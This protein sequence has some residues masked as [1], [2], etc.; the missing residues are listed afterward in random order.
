MTIIYQSSNNSITKENL[1]SSFER[2]LYTTSANGK[3]GCFRYGLSDQGPYTISECHCVNFMD[4]ISR[5]MFIEMPLMEKVQETFLRQKQLIVYSLGSGGCYQELSI[6][7]QLA[8][9]G[10]SIQKIVLVDHEYTKMEKDERVS[11][12]KRLFQ[13]LFS[14]EAKVSVYQTEKD[15]FGAIETLKEEKPDVILCID[16]ESERLPYRCDNWKKMAGDHLSVFVYHN[17]SHDDRDFTNSIET[18]GSTTI[19]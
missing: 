5:K 8:K 7:V 17:I 15:Y 4:R 1:I 3:K 9:H 18:I 12:F 13:T 10:Y 16:I 2:D 11:T 6:C 14:Q 19:T